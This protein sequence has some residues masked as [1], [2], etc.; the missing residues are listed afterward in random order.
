MVRKS[1]SRGYVCEKR[2]QARSFW[3]R[4]L[5]K[6]P[7]KRQILRFSILISTTSALYSLM[8]FEQLFTF[9]G[10]EVRHSDE[11]KASFE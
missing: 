8:V 6:M 10:Q 2:R 7:G 4:P 3:P 1:F 5:G 9:L 11:K